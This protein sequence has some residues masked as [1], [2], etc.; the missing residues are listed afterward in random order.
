MAMDRYRACE[1]L[2]AISSDFS[3]IPDRERKGEK[4]TVVAVT[5]RFYS[6]GVLH[7]SNL[8]K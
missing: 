5:S 8:S 3:A 6:P 2:S 1:T 4:Q 7:H